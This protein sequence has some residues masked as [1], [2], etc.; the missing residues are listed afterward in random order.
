MQIIIHV[1]TTGKAY[2]KKFFRDTALEWFVTGNDG[3]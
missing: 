3:S 1:A 2:I